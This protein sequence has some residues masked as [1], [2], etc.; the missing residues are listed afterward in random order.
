VI[1]IVSPVAPKGE[2]LVSVSVCRCVGVSASGELV[3]ALSELGV[4]TTRRAGAVRE[5]SAA[6][7]RLDD[8]DDLSDTASALADHRGLGGE[9]TVEAHE[10]ELNVVAE[11]A[12]D[13][14]LANHDDEG[15]VRCHVCLL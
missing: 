11:L 6:R 5:V 7:E 10:A 3:E 14:A 8:L 15:V 1:F 4:G 12:A 13:G 2:A 9:R